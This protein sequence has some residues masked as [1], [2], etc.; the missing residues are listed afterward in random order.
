MCINVLIQE[1][2][3]ILTVDSYVASIY[4]TDPQ[5]GTVC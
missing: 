3:K 4:Q 5:C 1:K 2:T